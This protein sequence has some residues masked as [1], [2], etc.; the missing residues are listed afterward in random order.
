[1]KRDDQVD[2][3]WVREVLHRFPGIRFFFETLPTYSVLYLTSYPAT[4]DD[5]FYHK[6]QF[7]LLT[8]I[9]VHLVFGA[10]PKRFEERGV[11]DF[12]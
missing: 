8:L 1:M 10:F 2:D 12:V 9:N 5:F 4:V 6:E 11:N 3:A 7:I